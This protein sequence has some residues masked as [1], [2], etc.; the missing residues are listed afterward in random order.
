MLP[1]SLLDSYSQSCILH[2]IRETRIAVIVIEIEVGARKISIVQEGFQSFGG[3]LDACEFNH[4]Y[5]VVCATNIKY[6]SS[7]NLTS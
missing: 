2:I 6:K 5:A 7:L 1:A 3:L 4:G